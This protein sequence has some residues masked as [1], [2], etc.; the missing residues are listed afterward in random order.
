MGISSPGLSVLQRPICARVQAP[1]GLRGGPRVLC[2]VYDG[3]GDGQSFLCVHTLCG[4]PLKMGSER[5]GRGLGPP[6][7]LV[8]GPA[9]TRDA[10]G[11]PSYHFILFVLSI[12]HCLQCVTFFSSDLPNWNTHSEGARALGCMAASPLGSLHLFGVGWG[13]NL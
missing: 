7:V 6:F 3:G 8:L 13:V 5:R 9:H 10:P 11:C 2:G 12:F 1:L 4:R